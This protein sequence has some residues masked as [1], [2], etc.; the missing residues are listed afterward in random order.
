MDILA[1]LVIAIGLSLDE[2]AVA[3]AVSLCFKGLDWARVF[4]LIGTFSLF[5]AVMLLLGYYLGH[6]LLMYI[7]NIDH[8]LAFGLLL[9]VGLRMVW[10]AFQEGET[11]GKNRDPTR[12]KELFLLALA[13][14]IDALAIGLSFAAMHTPIFVPLIV[15]LAMVFAF[16]ILGTQIGPLIGKRIG[17][18]AE[19]IGGLV[20]ILLGV[21]VL[22]DHYILN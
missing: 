10:E 4:R 21:K 16:G 22:L 6:E 9:F 7:E 13:T 20:L 12:G 14:S 19:V 1:L 8:W 15:I 5:H 2:F 17:R 18:Y 3:I 11:Y